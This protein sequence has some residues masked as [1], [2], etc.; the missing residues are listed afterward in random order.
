MELSEQEIDVMVSNLAKHFHVSKS[1]VILY[2]DSKHE[3][4][5]LSQEPKKANTA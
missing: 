1:D 2:L 5:A 3:K 4:K